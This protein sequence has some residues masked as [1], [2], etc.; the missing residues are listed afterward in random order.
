MLVLRAG[1]NYN[2]TDKAAMEHIHF[3]GARRIGLVAPGFIGY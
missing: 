2:A 3:V 1:L